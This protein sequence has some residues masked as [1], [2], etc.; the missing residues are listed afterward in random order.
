[1]FLFF[2]LLLCL[3]GCLTFSFWQ[4]KTT[5]VG[6]L[7][8]VPYGWAQVKLSSDILRTILTRP[9]Q[10]DKPNLNETLRLH[11]YL[12]QPVIGSLQQFLIDVSTPGHP[13][14]GEHLDKDEADALLRPA[15][16]NT[17]AV[18]SWLKLGG[19]PTEHIA[20]Q[21]HCLMFNVSVS[22]AE[23]LLNTEFHQ[24]HRGDITLIRTLQY[25][26][27]SI[28]RGLIASVQP[29]TRFGQPKAQAMT[30]RDM[31]DDTT[32]TKLPD[33]LASLIT[34]YNE[35]FCNST[36]TPAC[37]RGLYNFGDFAYDPKG[38]SLFGVAGFD[39]EGLY[40]PDVK[41]FLEATDNSI[42]SLPLTINSIN[43]GVLVASDSRTGINTTLEGNLDV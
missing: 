26:V 40:V 17:A 22:Q 33:D 5:V 36:M 18:K 1:M 3:R 28:L 6:S 39:G 25:S 43:N 19:I 7:T 23:K 34:K 32:A 8:R 9:A 21:G 27:P 24:Y 38:K 31:D 29:T 4:P 35:S 10:G 20:S 30:P 13:L 16:T 11:V 14:Y 15:D 42:K 12:E 41:D 37:I 2:C